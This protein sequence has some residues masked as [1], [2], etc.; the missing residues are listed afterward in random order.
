MRFSQALKKLEAM[1]FGKAEKLLTF[2]WCDVHEEILDYADLQKNFL[3]RHP[4]CKLPINCEDCR[5]RKYQVY[6][7]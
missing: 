7:L 6:P 4:N 5:H 1:N 2:Y 3:K